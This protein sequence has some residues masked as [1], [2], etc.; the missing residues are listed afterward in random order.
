MWHVAHEKALV[1][2]DNR[3]LA[4]WVASII[5]GLLDFLG[6]RTEPPACRNV[7]T[8]V[9]RRPTSYVFTYVELQST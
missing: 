1:G 9:R 3:H 8:L 6:R 7:Q 5:E 4:K 2:K